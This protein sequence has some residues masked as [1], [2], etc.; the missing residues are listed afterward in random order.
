[1]PAP[2]FETIQ[3]AVDDGVATVTLNRPE[4]LNAF[5]TQMMKDLIA[6]FD[7]TDA[8]DAVRAVIVTGAGRAFCAGADLSGGA[9]TFD[10]EAQ[11]GRA[12]AER[13]RDGVQ[14][15]GG[16]LL[17]LRI[18]DSLKPVI[19]AC[20]GPAVGVGVTMQLAMDIRLA[21]TD[22]RYGLVFARRG[23]NPEA[24]S[25]YFLPKLV[26]VQ[27]ALEWC[28]T[29]RIFPAA[30]A[31]EKGLVRSVHAPDDLLPAARAIAREIADNTAPVS[32]AITRQL[33][34]RMA[35]ASHPMEAH[36]ADSRG[37]QLRGRSGDAREGVS[38]FLEKRPPNYP[39]KVSSDLP[40]IWPHWQAPT[41]R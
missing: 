25:S 27:T 23:L 14:R 5:N 22:A 28:Y 39:D 7:E 30:E 33:I 26:G 16:G 29:G 31:H 34:W 15:D 12:L 13:Q 10:Y 38:S 40:D 20:N 35:G 1:M 4:K 37:I 18:F 8:D 24:A 17:T 9:Q 36:M 32:V 6:V 3:Y 19:S 21:S 2:T 11:G 41:F